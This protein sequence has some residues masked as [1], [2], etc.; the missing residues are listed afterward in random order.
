[1]KEVKLVEK[2]NDYITFES[3]TEIRDIVKALE[4]Y[5]DHHKGEDVETVQRMLDLLDVISM[6][7]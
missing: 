5:K 1:M 2:G 6:C 7:W 4:E 3:R